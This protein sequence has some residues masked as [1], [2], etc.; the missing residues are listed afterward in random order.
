MAV[1]HYFL[2]MPESCYV[3]HY[4][5]ILL[6]SD[7]WG[8]IFLIPQGNSAV[9]HYSQTPPNRGDCVAYYSLILQQ[10]VLA[11]AHYTLTVLNSV[12]VACCYLTLQN[13]FVCGPFIT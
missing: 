8:S 1:A 6:G 10:T 9:A 3:A 12:A 7:G 2:T 5:L 13:G 4:S 11:A